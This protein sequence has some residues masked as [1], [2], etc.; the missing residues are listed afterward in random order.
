MVVAGKMDRRITIERET[1][2]PSGWDESTWAPVVTVWAE[3]EHAQEDI[4][5]TEAGEMH[6]Q[7]T[8]FRT[9]WFDDVTVADRIGISPRSRPGLPL[10]EASRFHPTIIQTSGS[11]RPVPS[12]GRVE[13]RR[14]RRGRRNDWGPLLALNPGV[15]QISP[16]LHHVA[17]LMFI[18][19]LVIDAA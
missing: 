16:F 15:D 12:E 8:T 1:P 13:Q 4:Q 17:A 5:N 18:F 11:A 9:R 3:K 7:I 2:D 19:G 6:F 10:E 14:R